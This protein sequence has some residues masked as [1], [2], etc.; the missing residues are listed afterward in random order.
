MFIVLF[1]E[2]DMIFLVIYTGFLLTNSHGVSATA[3]TLSG[4]FNEPSIFLPL[5]RNISDNKLLTIRERINAFQIQNEE[6]YFNHIKYNKSVLST[7][8]IKKTQ[9][10]SIPNS[11]NVGD[12]IPASETLNYGSS[13]IID[14][15]SDSNDIERKTFERKRKK[16]RL[17]DCT[18]AGQV[19]KNGANFW[20]DGQLVCT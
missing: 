18:L 10:T 19:D 16:K 11:N 5:V 9:P 15:K 2:S 4:N 17:G 6:R 8:Y 13:S 1:V 14:R 12:S 7:T 20:I 3:V